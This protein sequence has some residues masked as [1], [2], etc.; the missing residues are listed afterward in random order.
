MKQEEIQEL[1]NIRTG[2]MGYYN[3]LDGKSNPGTSVTL[4]RDVAQVVE[5]TINRID[6]LLSEYVNFS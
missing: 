5:Q 3:T 4:Q 1:I 2:L 6:Q